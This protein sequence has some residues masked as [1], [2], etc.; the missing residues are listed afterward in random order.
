MARASKGKTG[1]A[2]KTGCSMPQRVYSAGI[3][4]RLSVDLDERKNE[5]IET[6]IEIARAFV[7]QQT[8]IVIYACYTD[9]GKSGT[10]FERDGFAQMMRDVR[11]RRID[12][13]IVKDL[14]RFGRNHIETGHYL[15]KIFPFLGVRFIAV[16]DCFDSR[17]GQKDALGVN[18]KNLVNEMYA[19]DI[20]RKVQSSKQLKREQGSYTGGVAPYGYR[21]E[22]VGNQRKLYTEKVTSGIVKKIYEL[23]LSGKSMKEI[24]VWLY[25]EEIARPS[26]YHRSGHVYCRDPHELTQWDSGTIRMI[27]TNPVYMGCSAEAIVSG[28]D[29]YRAAARLEKNAASGNEQRS[30]RM[31]QPDL[32]ADI[33]YCGACGAKMKRITRG[34]GAAGR[35]RTY[36]YCCPNH[37]RIDVQKCTAKCIALPVLTKIVK[38]AVR[39]ALACAV[40]R[41]EDLERTAKQ[42]AERIKGECSRRI[43]AYE[44]K[45]QNITRLESEQYIRYRMGEIDGPSFQRSQRCN[46]HKMASLQRNREEEQKKLRTIEERGGQPFAA[47]V[48]GITELTPR[49]IRALIH[50][51]EVYPDHRIKIIFAFCGHEFSGGEEGEED[52]AASDCNLYPA[53]EGGWEV[54]D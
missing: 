29:F 1:S 19:R 22:R 8:D 37:D 7:R 53:I 43:I 27:L 24:A 35:I 30:F 14:S 34:K 40:K 3:Y 51:I 2:G 10:N 42:E 38:D 54:R 41:P 46:D 13:I 4:A 26:Q 45:I 23:F 20:G 49:E 15:E 9:V 12:C 28:E 31:S 18:L 50:R 25:D 32:F 36:S 5:S 11:M 6:Q 48:S 16:T 39:F 21:V 44:R 47:F 33:L 52:E 17:S